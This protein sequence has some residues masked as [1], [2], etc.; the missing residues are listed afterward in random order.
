MKAIIPIAGRADYHRPHI[1][2]QAK[3]L[4]PIAGK[5]VIGHILDILHQKAGVTEFIFVTGAGGRRIDSYIE[6]AYKPRQFKT[7]FVLQEQRKG[8]AHAVLLA[9]EFINSN[10]KVLI[11][12]GDSIID[13]DFQSFINS[14]YNAVATKK[15]SKPCLFGIVETD[16]NNQVK[17]FTEKPRIPKSNLAMTGLFCVREP[18]I[19]FEAIQ[20]ML[21]KHN[22]HAEYFLT[23]ALMRM[24]DLEE[25]FMAFEVDRWYDCGK[26]DGLLEANAIHLAYPG[27]QTSSVKDFPNNNV[28]IQPVKIGRGCKIQNAII[29]PTVA[30]ANN[31][32][33]S[34]C[35]IS[36]SIIGSD[37]RI[38]HAI[39]NES[40]VGNDAVLQGFRQSLNLGDNTEINLTS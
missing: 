29:G 17:V 5:P 6:H 40:V 21:F 28:F 38:E 27:F 2:T 16:K 7:H 32:T 39:L 4:V 31:V 37:S 1:Y 9:Q 22:E 15:V 3:P 25:Q 26:K 8:S 19:L 20:D 34:N 35:I 12:F 10:E 11:A 36:D 30:I 33:V 14:P 23:D 13:L 24:I 18:K